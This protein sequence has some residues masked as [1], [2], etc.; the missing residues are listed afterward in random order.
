M[1][2]RG[3]RAIERELANERVAWTIGASG[4]RCRWDEISLRRAWGAGR[5]FAKLRAAGLRPLDAVR[6][7]P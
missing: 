5:A 7:K 3:E 2:P 1:K 6:R 4:G